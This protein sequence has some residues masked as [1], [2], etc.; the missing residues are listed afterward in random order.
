MSIKGH[1][2]VIYSLT[3]NANP[4][5]DKEKYVITGGSDHFVRI[6]RIPETFGEFY[7]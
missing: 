3:T 4:V 1:R 2:G 7:D 5:E 6:W